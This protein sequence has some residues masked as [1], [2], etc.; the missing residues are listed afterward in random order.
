MA[1]CFTYAGSGLRWVSFFLSC[2]TDILVLCRFI[3]P[4]SCHSLLF[5]EECTRAQGTHSS[6]G[7]EVLVYT[8]ALMK[9]RSLH[10]IRS[11]T[12]TI[13]M[14]RD[15]IEHNSQKYLPVSKTPVVV[16]RPLP[17]NHLIPTEKLLVLYSPG[18]MLCVS[19]SVGWCRTQNNILIHAGSV[20]GICVLFL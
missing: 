18:G 10:A 17:P 6:Q 12:K 14:R 9:K 5:S 3:W 16:C 20:Y 15:I 4:S 1:P 8:T 11:A 19:A 13:Q 7:L 2:V